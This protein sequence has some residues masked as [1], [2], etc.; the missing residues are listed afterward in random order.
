MLVAITRL[1]ALADVLSVTIGALPVWDG[2]E[3]TKK[4]T[5]TLTL[6]Q[7]QGLDDKLT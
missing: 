3:G 4:N 7:H 1:E 5:L 6:T 2:K